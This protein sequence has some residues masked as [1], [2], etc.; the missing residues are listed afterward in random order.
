MTFVGVQTQIITPLT[1]E[2]RNSWLGFII[3][4]GNASNSTN[5]MRI[6]SLMARF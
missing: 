2:D 3:L 5:K 6:G 4:G 1:T